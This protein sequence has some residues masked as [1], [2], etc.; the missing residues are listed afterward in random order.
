[1]KNKKI[2]T[3]IVIFKWE[4]T[5]LL[6]FLFLLMGCG[7][8]NNK[9][10]EDMLSGDLIIFHAGSLSVPFKEIADSFERRHPDVNIKREA[11]GSVDCARKIRDLGRDCDIMASADYKV[12]DKFLMPYYT[13]WQVK[14]AAN[15][16]TLVYHDESKYAG[17][18]NQNNWH[19]L[20]MREDV[21]YGRSDPDSDPCGY[22]TV[23]TVKLA[24]KYYDSPQLASQILSKDK[25]YMRPKETDLL[26]LLESNTI[27]YI[28]LYRSVAEQHGLE[29]LTFPDSLNLGNPELEEWYGSV[30]VDIAG[31]EP[32][33]KMTMQGEPMVYGVTM[34]KNAPNPDAAR[35][36]MHFLLS[37]DQGLRIMEKN[38]Q[39]SLVP[40]SSAYYDKLPLDFRVYTKP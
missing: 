24:E 18:I 34:L 14:F 33:K 23:L 36:F 4:S 10:N 20:I 30:S 13:D 19:D 6:L 31:R 9:K 29:Y 32:G 39:A 21:L 1:M 17:E 37:K 8:N 27:D 3:N 16:M 40:A 38:G 28:F 11:A 7:Q 2:P 12:I 22:R 35:A 26:A 5:L 25:R 15:E